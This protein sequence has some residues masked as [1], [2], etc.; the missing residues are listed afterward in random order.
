MYYWCR[1]RD[2]KSCYGD[3]AKPVP[4]IYLHKGVGQNEG[5]YNTEYFGACQNNDRDH[6]TVY[7]QNVYHVD[8]Y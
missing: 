6:K 8:R 5:T 3:H 1:K 4:L 7:P 2:T